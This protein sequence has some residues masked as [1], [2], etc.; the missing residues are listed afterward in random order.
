MIL[1]AATRPAQAIPCPQRSREARS[2][3]L[4]DGDSR[5]VGREATA[6]A[7]LMLAYEA[8]ELPMRAAILA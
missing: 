6:G 2:E 1:R 4:L 7:D 3:A 5:A 8:A